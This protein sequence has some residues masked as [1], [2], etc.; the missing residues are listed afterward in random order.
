MVI[1]DLQE[2][3]GG[4]FADQASQPGQL[5]IIEIRLDLAAQASKVEVVAGWQCPKGGN[6]TPPVVARGTSERCFLAGSSGA[7]S[8]WGRGKRRG[9]RGG[10]RDVPDCAGFVEGA[11]GRGGHAVADTEA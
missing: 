10:W 8:G 6:D 7:A 3:I 5:R 4:E 2:T 9:I 1:D 11:W